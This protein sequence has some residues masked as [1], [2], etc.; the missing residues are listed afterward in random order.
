MTTAIRDPERARAPSVSEPAAP[1]RRGRRERLAR[2][3]RPLL[4]AGLALVVAHLLDLAFSGPDTS[5][6]GVAAI[7]ALAAAWALAQPHVI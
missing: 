4:L 1:P 2:A 7:V 5:A 6:L 3:E